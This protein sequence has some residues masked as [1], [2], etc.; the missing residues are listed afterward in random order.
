MYTCTGT[1]YTNQNS[2]LRELFFLMCNKKKT[3]VEFNSIGNR[4][5]LWHDVCLHEELKKAEEDEQ[6]WK[7]VFRIDWKKNGFKHGTICNYGNV[8]STKSLGR[9][10]KPMQRVFFALK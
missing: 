5:R 8:F 1:M 2:P 3:S 6:T 4:E 9:E 7:D 10:S